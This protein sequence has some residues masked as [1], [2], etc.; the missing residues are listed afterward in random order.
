MC[1]SELKGIANYRENL[2]K[3]RKVLEDL[4]NSRD[5]PE[6]RVEV[7]AE[8]E[9]VFADFSVTNKLSELNDSVKFPLNVL[10]AEES[11]ASSDSDSNAD[12]EQNL[13]KPVNC[14]ICEKQFLNAGKLRKHLRKAKCQKAS[15]ES[16]QCPT[17]DEIL[18]TRLK[19]DRHIKQCAR[20]RLKAVKVFT[21]ETNKICKP[22]SLHRKEKKLNQPVKCPVCEMEFFYKV[23]LTHHMWS[24]HQDHRKMCPTC[25]AILKNTKGLRNHMLI[26]QEKTFQCDVCSKLFHTKSSLG[27]HKIVSYAFDM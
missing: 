5:T 15:N 21:T 20:K 12:N 7:K 17:C 14:H 16:F 13:H 4:Y 25:G 1:S 9:S 23:Y 26:H 24:T 10:I 22:N 2:L 18:L 27:R 11:E 6:N 19:L 8:N 3:N